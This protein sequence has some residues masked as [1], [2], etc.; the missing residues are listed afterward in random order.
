VA[1]KRPV[2]F[3]ILCYSHRRPSRGKVRRRYARWREENG[4]P[5]RCDIAACCFHTTAPSW[6]GQELSLILDHANGNSY[7]NRPDNLRLVCPNCDSQ[8]PTRGG[9]NKGRVKRHSD[10]EFTI[11]EK[12]GT[13]HYHIVPK[14]GGVRL[15]GSAPVEFKSGATE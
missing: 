9:R 2:T 6:N 11:M 4:L 15:G 3:E 7:D 10:T 14:G 12:N 1:K 8:L 5:I 13:R